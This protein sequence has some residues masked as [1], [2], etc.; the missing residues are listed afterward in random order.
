M[1]VYAFG[2][3]NQVNYENLQ[4]L[5]TNP[6]QAHVIKF[7]DYEKIYNLVNEKTVSLCNKNAFK[8]ITNYDW[9][10]FKKKNL[11]CEIK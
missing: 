11:I 3:S 5:A 7:S 8:F 4:I 6:V 1:E 9:D 2:I 10:L